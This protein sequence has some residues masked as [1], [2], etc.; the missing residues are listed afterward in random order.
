[1]CTRKAKILFRS[2][3]G[4]HLSSCFDVRQCAM[5]L[6]ARFLGQHFYVV[7]VI[8]PPPVAVWHAVDSACVF[9]W[10]SLKK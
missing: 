8:S 7:R 2:V 4:V 6:F 10:L 9:L 5:I 3:S 1:M